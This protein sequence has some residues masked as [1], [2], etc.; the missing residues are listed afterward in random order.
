MD[1]LTSKELK[2]MMLLSCERIERDKEDIN[3]INVFPVP[4]Q[5]TGTNL[6][7]TLI[8]IRDEIQDKDFSDLVNISSAILNGAMT[9]AQGNAGIIYTGF[10][11]GFFSFAENQNSIGGQEL[12]K[13]FRNG[14]QRAR[15]SIQSPKKGTILDIIEATASSFEQ[16]SPKE[17]NIIILFQFAIQE[18]KKALIETQNQMEIL[19]KANVVDAGGMGFL[20]ILE[21]YLD[22]LDGIQEEKE[23]IFIEKPSDQVK[24][25]IQ[26]IANRYEIVALLENPKITVGEIQERLSKFGNSIDV[27]SFGGQMKVHVHTDMIEE[28]K[29]IIRSAGEIKKMRIEDMAKESAKE[30]SLRDLSIGVMTDN[31]SDLTEKIIERYEIKTINPLSEDNFINTCNE[32]FKKFKKILIIVSSSEINSNYEKAMDFRSKLSDPYRAYVFDSL[33][34]SSG[35]DLL[36]LKVIS[37][38]K[39]QRGVREIIRIIDKRTQNIETYLCL[40]TLAKKEEYEFLPLPIIRWIK[41]WQGLG[42]MPLTEIKRG[43]WNR[44]DFFRVNNPS[45][46][47][48]AEIKKR[49][50]RVRRSGQKIRVVIAHKNNLEQAEALKKKLKEISAEV[51]FINSISPS[52][53][54]NLIE[55]SIMASWDIIDGNY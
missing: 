11:A 47:L 19:K 52:F 22:S 14:Y 7:K 26:T 3:K 10:L 32:H 34:I 45:D 5:D 50:K 44:A 21:S 17:K 48:F 51:S 53:G 6:S 27:I 24:R 23:K 37:L 9:T 12:A 41:R 18:A 54:Q 49:S 28:C 20:M 4:D 15:E 35:Q 30:E 42:F 33:H 36:I 8:G 46:A 55:G 13:C 2:R 31:G 40:P 29:E 25:F 43:Q 1:Y 16:E 39:E 38:I